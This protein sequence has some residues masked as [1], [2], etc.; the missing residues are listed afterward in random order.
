[1]VQAQVI[2][3]VQYTI[4]FRIAKLESVQLECLA[5]LF[6]AASASI[7]A[8]KPPKPIGNALRVMIYFES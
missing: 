4:S 8:P 6:P 3:Y 2:H 5:S 7:A 1:M